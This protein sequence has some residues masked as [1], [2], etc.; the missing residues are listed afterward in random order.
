[1]GRD[2]DLGGELVGG[3][4]AF[5]HRAD[6]ADDLGEVHHADPGQGAEQERVGVLV[7]RCAESGFE[8]GDT[9]GQGA[10]LLDL[11]GDRGGDG[12]AAD[13]ASTT[14]LDR[15]QRSSGFSA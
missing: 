6:L 12:V 5:Q 11:R 15:V 2:A 3:Q 7:Q 14:C 9:A 10:D 8:V 1:M 13:P 4:A